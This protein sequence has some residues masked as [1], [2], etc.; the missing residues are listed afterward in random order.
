MFQG[1]TSFGGVK[2]KAGFVVVVC[3]YHVDYLASADKEISDW[4]FKGHI[5]GIG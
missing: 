1:K 4:L 5:P 2:R 3:F